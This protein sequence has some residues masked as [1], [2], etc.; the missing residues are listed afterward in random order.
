MG[1]KRALGLLTDVLALCSITII[2][3]TRILA[4]PMNQDRDSTVRVGEDDEQNS[5][6]PSGSLAH[7]IQ[8]S[9]PFLPSDVLPPI[10]QLVCHTNHAS[11]AAL[12]LSHVSRDW[13]AAALAHKP[14]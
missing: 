4:D 8:Q 5:T 2:I 14:L 7:D 3:P 1:C 13:R 10:F 6:L 12:T 11:T 9:I